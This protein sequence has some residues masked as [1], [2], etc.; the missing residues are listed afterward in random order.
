MA[1]IPVALTMYT[2]REEAARDYMGA[3]RQALEMGY[4]GLQTHYRACDPTQLRELAGDFGARVCGMHVSIDPLRSE[5]DA[6]AEFALELGCRDVTC[7]Y[8][9]EEFRGEEGFRRAAEALT[10]AGQDLRRHGIRLT[11]HNHSFEFQPCGASDGFEVLF[12][13]V[14]P[15]LVLAELDV[16]W[17]RHG[18]KDPVEY[19]R[20]FAGRLPLLHIKDME[21][22]EERFF[23]EI[24]EGILD[25]PA[26]FAAAEDAGVEWAIVEQDAC[27][28]P[29][30]ESARLSLENLKKMGL[31]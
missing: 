16:Y 6:V 18:G 8:L 13:A 3:S 7:P 23:A 5:P 29:P 14:D 26:I 22:G 1:A 31:A 4:A 10:D 19:I 20:R 28:R 24:G 9:P 11:Y 12:G 25:W 15:K 21:P 27:R 17:L 2:L 30:L